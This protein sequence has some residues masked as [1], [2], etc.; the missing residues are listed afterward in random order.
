MKIKLF[1][2]YNK[3]IM[4]DKF[5]R[6]VQYDYVKVK[7]D[8]PFRELAKKR[9][10]QITLWNSEDY[11]LKDIFEVGK[12]LGWLAWHHC[13]LLTDSEKKELEFKLDAKKYNL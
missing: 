10:F 6:P 9:F 13:R 1:D 12:D 7:D 3:N 2:D 5:Q 8:S 4:R 11:F